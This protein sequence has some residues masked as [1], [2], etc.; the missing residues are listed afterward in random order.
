M[1]DLVYVE[2][3]LPI[4]SLLKFLAKRADRDAIDRWRRVL[5]N[6]SWVMRIGEKLSVLTAFAP[7]PTFVSIPFITSVPLL[8]IS[9]KVRDYWMLRWLRTHF[10]LNRPVVWI[11]HP[12]LSVEVIRGLNP[13]LLWYDCTEDLT[14]WPGLP[15]CVRTQIA[16]TDQWLTKNANVVTAV[17]R[18]LYEEKKQVNRCTYWLP[19]AV[20]TDLFQRIPENVPVPPELQNVS[21]PVLAFVGG[22]NDWA[23]DWDLLDHVVTL[24]PAWTILLIGEL[25]V[26]REIRKMLQNHTN[27][28][29]IGQKP[30]R[31]LP[32]YLLHSDVCFQFYRHSRENDTRNSQKLFLYFA[33][34]KPVVSTP[35]ADVEVYDGLV[36]I[37]ET[38]EAFVAGVERAIAED[39]SGAVKVRQEIARENSWSSRVDR[40]CQILS[41]LKKL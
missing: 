24:R 25:S 29:C 22:L 8:Q 6:H 13:C 32:P 17:S 20:D 12:Q 21:P 35:S 7:L 3:P 38:A 9:E 26:S 2:R 4:T 31:E 27:I 39:S 19:N 1:E 5:F 41:D 30:Y 18:T 34:G 10:Y 14:A 15:K 23:H 28:L 11:S 37:V 16:T 40:I 36:R 33:A